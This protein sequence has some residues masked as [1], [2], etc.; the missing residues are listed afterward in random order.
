MFHRWI[1]RWLLCGWLSIALAAAIWHNRSLVRWYVV[2]W[3]WNFGVLWKSVETFLFNKNSIKKMWK[4]ELYLTL[5]FFRSGGLLGLLFSDDGV[6]DGYLT[7]PELPFGTGIPRLLSVD[8]LV[9]S[10]V[11]G[12]G[13][14]VPFPFI[15]CGTGSCLQW[16][17]VKKCKSIQVKSPASTSSSL[18]SHNKR[19]FK[20]N[21]KERQG[22]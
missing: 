4:W 7:K 21:L 6:P 13:I 3:W 16:M 17:R 19:A 12:I 18:C 1:A 10:T 9:T 20:V 15:F 8:R 14:A 5:S 2:W 11:A 22:I